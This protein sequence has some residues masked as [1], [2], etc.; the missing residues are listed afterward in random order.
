MFCKYCDL[1]VC[2][3][4]ALKLPG[5]GLLALETADKGEPMRRFHYEAHKTSA[6]FTFFYDRILLHL[7]QQDPLLSL[8]AQTVWF[9]LA[10]YDPQHPVSY[11]WFMLFLQNLFELIKKDYAE[12]FFIDSMNAEIKE[13]G[14]IDL[15][16]SYFDQE[17]QKQTSLKATQIINTLDQTRPFETE[18]QKALA[19]FSWLA[20]NIQ[21]EDYETLRYRSASVIGA[22]LDGKAV[23]TGISQAFVLL[24]NAAGLEAWQIFG[25]ATDAIS[26]EPHA[27]NLVRID[28]DYYH[29]DVTAAMADYRKNDKVSFGYFLQPDTRMQSTHT[30]LTSRYPKTKSFPSLTNRFY[31]MLKDKEDMQAFAEMI[32]DPELHEDS[33]L[34]RLNHQDPALESNLKELTEKTWKLEKLEE[35]E[36]RLF[37]KEKKQ[38]MSKETDREN[39]GIEENNES[40]QL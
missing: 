14:G 13:D 16:F 18:S 2:T 39:E 7:R 17:E 37:R 25:V 11:G 4:I 20:E 1:P 3:L 6:V 34:V 5:L 27:W 28:G 32:K 15:R 19:I 10:E 22:L 21:Y 12:L 26:T 33:F 30:W 36:F 8:E 24:A 31:S 38:D 29:L 23:C 9:W 35:D 40:G